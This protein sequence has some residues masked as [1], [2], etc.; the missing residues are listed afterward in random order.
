MERGNHLRVQQDPAEYQKPLK[1]FQMSEEA[2]PASEQNNGVA[3]AREG[4]S[5][6]QSWPPE[7]MPPRAEDLTPET[8]P[9]CEGW[10]NGMERHAQDFL[11]GTDI[12][13]VQF[14]LWSL[15]PSTEHM[16][17][18]A[19][20]LQKLK[21]DIEAAEP[22]Q[23]QSERMPEQPAGWTN[24]MTEFVEGSL[25][26]GNDVNTTVNL[27]RLEIAEAF[28]IQGLEEHVE[29]LRNEYVRGKE[30]QLQQD[31][32]SQEPFG[33]ND[34]MTAIIQEYLRKGDRD[35]DL[36]V[37]SLEVVDPDALFVDGV[38]EH[39]TKLMLKFDAQGQDQKN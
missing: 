16:T 18:L 7:L 10:T 33:W 6:D 8:P 5:T 29:K 19:R 14:E 39:V 28:D 13:Q 3:V 11:N 37:E 1:I 4:S 22:D 38:N 15:Y 32:V 20:Y 9:G 27:F 17:G 25:C 30:A 36:M 34:G 35:V 21:Q 26:G 2:S 23:V 24:Q 31:Q 12:E